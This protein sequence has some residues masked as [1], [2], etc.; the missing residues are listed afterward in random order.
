MIIQT[1]VEGKKKWDERWAESAT[2]QAPQ[3][4]KPKVMMNIQDPYGLIESMY[5]RLWGPVKRTEIMRLSR[6]EQLQV[7][8][9]HYK[10]EDK[11]VE[12]SRHKVKDIVELVF[13]GHEIGIEETDEVNEYGR[14]KYKVGAD[15]KVY[16]TDTPGI[17][18]LGEALKEREKN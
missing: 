6:I 16:W 18:Y 3:K 9:D 15:A 14:K 13:G 5:P 8:Y 10:E 17:I 12:L 7:I 11:K 1:G 2:M 4:G